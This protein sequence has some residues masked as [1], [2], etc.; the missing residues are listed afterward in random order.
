MQMK[1]EFGNFYKQNNY[2]KVKNRKGWIFLKHK[3]N[4]NSLNKFKNLLT[5]YNTKRNKYFRWIY[6]NY[7]RTIITAYQIFQFLL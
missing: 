7:N 5:L 6:T 3:I 2:I 4:E 1:S